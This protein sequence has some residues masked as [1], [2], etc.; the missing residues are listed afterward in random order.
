MP[1]HI[2][3]KVGVRAGDVLC[4]LGGCRLKDDDLASMPRI[5]RESVQREKRM[6]VARKTDGVYRIVSFNFPV[7]LM[8]VRFCE[9]RVNEHEF[10][11]IQVAYCGFQN[12]SK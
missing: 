2:A 10:N 6:V 8:G 9:K 5:I 3:A 4:E 11:E 12:K 7:G 1:G